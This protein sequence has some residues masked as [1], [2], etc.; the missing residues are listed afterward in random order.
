MKLKTNQ[1]NK[2]EENNVRTSIFPFNKQI[3]ILNLNITRFKLHCIKIMFI[4]QDKLSRWTYLEEFGIILWLKLLKE[5]F[6]YKL[7][8]FIV[9]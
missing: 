3:T 9:M 6:L 4:L 8:F 7:D 1:K 2:Q 5:T